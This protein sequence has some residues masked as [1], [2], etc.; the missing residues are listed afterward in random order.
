MY[1]IIIAAITPANSANNA[2]GK[3]CLVRFMPTAPKYTAR[4]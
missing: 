2:H 1:E 3:A 4:T